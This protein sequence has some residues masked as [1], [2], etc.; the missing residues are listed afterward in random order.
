MQSKRFSGV[1]Q[2]AALAVIALVLTGAAAASGARPPK[3]PSSATSGIDAQEVPL[4]ERA[5][6]VKQVQLALRQRGYY[7]G[8]ISGFLGQPTYVAI[9]MFEIDH[10]C[11]HVRPM[12]DNCLLAGLG[13][14]SVP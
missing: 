4:S 13:I 5:P 8:T 3:V 6:V 14:R 11:D 7:R 2:Y 12:V 10:H 9:Q 1:S